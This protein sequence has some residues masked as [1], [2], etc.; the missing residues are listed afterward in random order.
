MAYYGVLWVGYYGA[1][2][3]LSGGRTVGASWCEPLNV[4][5]T[6]SQLHTGAH[7]RCARAQIHTGERESERARESESESERTSALERARKRARE[8]T[9]DSQLHRLRLV[10]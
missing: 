4:A 6:D 2:W 5:V 9:A 7:T 8:G 3:A 10:A 1:L